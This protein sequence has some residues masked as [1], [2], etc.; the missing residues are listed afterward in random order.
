VGTLMFPGSK[1]NPALFASISVL[2]NLEH[3]A[4]IRNKVACIWRDH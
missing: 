1:I 2:S 3:P 4:P